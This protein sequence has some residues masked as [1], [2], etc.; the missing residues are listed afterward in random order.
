[1]TEPNETDLTLHAALMEKLRLVMEDV[2]S[3]SKT[4]HNK[5]QGYAFVEASEVLA[6]V[7]ESLVKCGL[8]QTVEI[9]NVEYTDGSNRSGNTYRHYFVW[10]LV[11][12]SDCV[13]G[14]KCVLP[15][16]GESIDY[17]DKGIGKAETLGQKQFWLKTLLIDTGDTDPDG[18]T[19][20]GEGD[21]G[22]PSGSRHSSGSSGGEVLSDPG[23]FVM[24]IT[25]DHKGKT[26]RQ[27]AEEGNQKLFQ[28][29]LDKNISNPDLIANV[30][31]YMGMLDSNAPQT[32]QNQPTSGVHWTQTQDW[33]EFYTKIGNTLGLNNNDVHAA[34]KV[35]SAKNYKGSKDEAWKALVEF[36]TATVQ[37]WPNYSGLTA[38][39]FKFLNS[40]PDA[41]RPAPN[42]AVKMLVG[43][44]G[45]LAQFHD[46]LAV[47]KNIV[48]AQV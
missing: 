47:A 10:M 13:T 2:V 32:A 41:Q 39:W 29:V 35:D 7:H 30:K 1:M 18:N 3:L 48:L 15:W 8:T 17:Q 43:E 11:T 5:D 31:A 21:S 38:E 42:V 16:V 19:P 23:S 25:K 33:Q 9:T 20:F 24:P 4:G 12:L 40:I 28:W 45:N 36:A 46:T 27:I 26:L 14:Y 34:L 44:G 37:N 22:S 6:A